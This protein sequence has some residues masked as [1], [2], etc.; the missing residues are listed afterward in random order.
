MSDNEKPDNPAEQPPAPET[1]PA[2]R[3][4]R[5]KLFREK[6]ADRQRQTAPPPKKV[7]SLDHELSY[8]SGKKIDAFD[9][10]MERELQEAMG[11]FESS[12]LITEGPPQAKRGKAG[13]QAE[14]KKG[15]V[16]RIH[17]PDVFIDLPGGR[18]QG[19]LPMMQFPEGP[20]TIGQ[21]V[22]VTIEGFDNANG[23]IILSRKGAAMTAE[24]SSV[25]EGQ[26]VEARVL[27]T[28][29]GG[30][31]VDVNGIRGFMPIS[32]IDLYRVEDVEQFVNQKL[33]CVIT[34][35]DPEE[36]NLVV[37]R[38]ALLEKDREENREKLW[39]QLAEGQVYDGIVRSLKEFGAFVDIGGVDGLLHVSEM[40]WQRV[41]D[42]SKFV[43][44]G[45]KVKVVV[46]RIDAEKR[47]VSFGMKQLTESPWDAADETY[48]YGTIVTGKVTRLMD[49]GAFVE[50][51]PGVEG[52]IHIS[53]LS[54]ARVRRVIDVVKAGQD[55]QVMVLSVDKAQRR[56]ALSLK[57]ALPKEP[58]PEPTPEAEE[59]E[60]VEVKPARPRTT[61]LRGGIGEKPQIQL[62]GQE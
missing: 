33:R 24:W 56:I 21:E 32:Q 31:A 57:A 2:D 14:P 22:E 40:S 58:E 20:P 3:P 43:Q 35:V 47:K 52:L 15:R 8:G 5:A 11:D 4:D 48:P 50:L 7:P 28:N 45:Q 60:V 34:E 54:P 42:V 26:I 53:E 41:A 6:A 13:V 19:I 55:V 12:A 51:E 27:E 9:A 38:R 62:G 36:R 39:A 23:L 59:E 44:P 29:K 16:F 30:L 46:L 18:S 49:F 1:P 61:P 25:A 17:G 10:D 37:S